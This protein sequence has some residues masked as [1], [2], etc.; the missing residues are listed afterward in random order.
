MQPK[1]Y[2][3][4]LATNEVFMMFAPPPVT[5]VEEPKQPSPSLMFLK[6]CKNVTGA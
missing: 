5:S 2:K 1:I 4:I 3:H 6:Y